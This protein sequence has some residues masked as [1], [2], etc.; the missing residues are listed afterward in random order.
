MEARDEAFRDFIKETLGTG[1]FSSIQI[2]GYGFEPGLGENIHWKPL[3]A[4]K[5]GL[6]WK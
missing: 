5:K 2:T 4:A 3:H 1:L 6:L